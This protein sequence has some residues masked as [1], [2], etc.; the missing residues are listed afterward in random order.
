MNKGRVRWSWLG[1]VA[2]TAVAMLF[3]TAAMFVGEFVATGVADAVV[4]ALRDPLEFAYELPRF[5]VGSVIVIC[6]AWVGANFTKDPAQSFVWLMPAMPVLLLLGLTVA[7]LV[8]E[9]TRPLSG[10]PP[11]ADMNSAHHLG[12]LVGAILAGIGYHLAALTF[13]KFGRNVRRP[14]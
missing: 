2:A 4:F 7:P 11:F 10:R 12:N 5:I 14:A 3:L 1:L 6:L 8:L 9:L 13:L